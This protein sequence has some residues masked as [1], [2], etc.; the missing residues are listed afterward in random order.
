MDRREQ[1]AEILCRDCH[2]PCD[3]YETIEDAER[4]CTSSTVLDILALGLDSC[5][6]RGV[7]QRQPKV[8]EPICRVKLTPYVED[9]MSCDDRNMA[10]CKTFGRINKAVRGENDGRE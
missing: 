10:G 6:L 5:P 2:T 3:N 1:I 9:Y 4:E 8:G 7:R